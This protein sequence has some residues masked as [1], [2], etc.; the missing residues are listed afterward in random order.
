MPISHLAQFSYGIFCYGD[1]YI[2]MTTFANLLLRVLCALTRAHTLLVLL[3]VDFTVLFLL[4]C[5]AFLF[6]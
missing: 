2:G 5:V 6:L 1:N 4:S 3:L